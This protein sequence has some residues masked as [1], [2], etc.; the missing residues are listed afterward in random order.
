MEM[1]NEDLQALIECFLQEPAETLAR[2]ETN[3][4]RLEANPADN[5]SIEEVFRAVHT[6]KGSSAGV[7]LKGL[8]SFTHELE[9]LLSQVKKGRA[10][11]PA[12]ISALLQGLD[13]IRRWID[14]VQRGNKENV[15][16]QEALL[17]IKSLDAAEAAENTNAAGDD[18]IV[19]LFSP[20][21]G[22]CLKHPTPMNQL[23][24]SHA[25]HHNHQPRQSDGHG[26]STRNFRLHRKNRE[27]V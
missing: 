6:I 3:I 13:A 10:V 22:E 14:E 1:S 8:A 12:L 15:D 20:E 26:L 2:A 5:K 21:T 23:E 4:L 7:G 17:A 11:T 19:F 18:D 9:S 27:R 25:Q 24:P 16:V